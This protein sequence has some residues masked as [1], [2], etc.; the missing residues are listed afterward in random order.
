MPESERDSQLRDFLEATDSDGNTAFTL[1]AKM[2]DL[3]SVQLLA[4]AGAD[5][6]HKNKHSEDA[7]KVSKSDDVIKFIKKRLQ[8]I[9]RYPFKM[10]GSSHPGTCIY[11]AND[12]YSD[13]SLAMGYDENSVRERFQT[14][15][16]YKFIPYT[17]LTAKK[18]QELMLDL[19]ERDFSSSASFVCFVS[20]HGSSDEETNKDYMRGMEPINPRTESAGKQLISLENFTE[21]ISNNRTLRGKPKIF[22]YQACRTFQTGL[23]QKAVKTAKR[24]RQPNQR[25]AADLLEVHATSR[26]D[27]AFRHQKGTLFLQ[28]FCQYMWEYMDTEH[29][30]DIVDR[31][32]D[33]LN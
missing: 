9:G 3:R 16:K 25:Q 27:A 10:P 11:I 31:L 12:P 33:H 6:R 22:F 20:S 26:G 21:P 32:A 18:M 19:Q 13:R 2:E 4:D 15:L 7:I 14:E 1:A 23:R 30:R 5:L 17:N 24:T 29:L 8:I 28:E